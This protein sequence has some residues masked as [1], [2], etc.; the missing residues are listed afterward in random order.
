MKKELGLVTGLALIINLPAVCK[1]ST[2]KIIN[3]IDL[4]IIY[5]VD[6]PTKMPSSVLHPWLKKTP[7]LFRFKRT[8]QIGHKQRALFESRKSPKTN[9]L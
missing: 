4:Y 5:I 1:G 8:T 6:L 9:E 2:I 7:K 3:T